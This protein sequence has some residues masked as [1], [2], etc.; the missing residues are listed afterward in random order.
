MFVS[1]VLGSMQ[2][3]VSVKPS[4]NQLPTFTNINTLKLSETFETVMEHDERP[5]SPNKPS[6]SRTA[7]YHLHIKVGNGNLRHSQTVAIQNLRMATLKLLFEG[8]QGV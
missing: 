1:K 5:G 4:Q 6:R 7:V 2:F 3:V 8:F